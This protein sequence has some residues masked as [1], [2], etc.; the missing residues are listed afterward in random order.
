MPDDN[1][2]QKPEPGAAAPPGDAKQEAPGADSNAPPETPPERTLTQTEVNAILAREK[3]SWK[4][5][6]EDE[7]RKAEMTEADRLKAEKAEAETRAAESAKT[8][9]LRI[10]RVEARAAL[11]DAGVR[12]DRRDYAL[13]MLD[14]DSVGAGDDGEPDTKAIATLVEKL[15]AAVPELK[16]SGASSG[17]TE[18]RGGSAEPDPASMTMP[19]YAAWRQKQSG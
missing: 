5:T 8:A 9:N 19:Q 13:R 2:Q 1:Q 10:A 3:A 4:K 16:S 15:L 6:A 11:A 18:F 7:R 17:G 12:A 14:L